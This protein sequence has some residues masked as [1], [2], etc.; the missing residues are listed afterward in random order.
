MFPVERSC[1]GAGTDTDTRTATCDEGTTFASARPALVD[2][3]GCAILAQQSG[4]ADPV[5]RVS[6]ALIGSGAR[7]DP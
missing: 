6:P 4:D 1:A 5:M 2:V 7:P 3:G